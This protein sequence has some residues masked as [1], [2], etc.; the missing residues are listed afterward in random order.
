MSKAKVSLSPQK[1]AAVIFDMDGV[2]TRTAHVHAAA[3]K[4]MFDAFLAEH[5]QRSDEEFQPG[6]RFGSDLAWHNGH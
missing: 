2:V 3:W 4:K 5:A 6:D 1:F